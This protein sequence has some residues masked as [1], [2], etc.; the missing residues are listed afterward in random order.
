MARHPEKVTPFYTALFGWTAKRLPDASTPYTE[1]L[2]GSEHGIGMVDMPASFDETVPSFWLLYFQV[3][4]LDASAAKARDLGATL[5]IGPYPVPG[6]GR[7]TIHADPQGALFALFD[8][9][10]DQP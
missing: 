2:V 6:T 10:N 7:L 3:D 9:D 1:F 4:D 8:Y 5:V